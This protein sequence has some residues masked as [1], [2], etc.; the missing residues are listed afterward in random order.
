MDIYEE[1][2]WFLPALAALC[3]A[4]FVSFLICAFWRVISNKIFFRKAPTIPI[5][6]H[7]YDIVENQVNIQKTSPFIT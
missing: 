2:S 5:K 6:D 7:N 1:Y 3:A 4:S